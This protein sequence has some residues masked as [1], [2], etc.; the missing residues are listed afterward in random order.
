[1]TLLQA[2]FTFAKNIAKLITYAYDIDLNITIGEV[3]RTKEQ[4]QIY[5]N[6]GKS[7]TLD[8]Y[9]LIKLACD[10][11]LFKGTA[12]LSSK[13]SYNTLGLYWKSLHEN[14]NWGGDW[15]FDANHFEMR[16]TPRTK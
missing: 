13:D 15:G 3:L 2:Q 12:L 16:L 8:S 14:N 7:K 6:T 5:F 4:Q 11:N 1:M 9:H 10:L